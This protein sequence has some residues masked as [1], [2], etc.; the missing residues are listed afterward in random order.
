MAITVEWD[1][2]EQTVLRLTFL[3]SWNWNELFR[4][5]DVAESM[6][7]RRPVRVDAILDLSDAATMLAGSILKPSFRAQA[8]TLARR[9]TGRHGRIVVVGANAWIVSMYGMFRG[10]LGAR[11]GTVMFTDSLPQ[12]YDMLSGAPG[13][14]PFGPSPAEAA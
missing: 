12:A 4:A 7:A 3:G 1:N 10:L 11:A 13:P 5:I 2:V 8:Q 14:A 9:A 6:A